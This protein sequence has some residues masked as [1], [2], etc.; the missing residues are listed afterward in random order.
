MSSLLSRSSAQYLRSHPWLMALSVLG[1]A[2]GVAIVVAIDLAN[3]SAS[4]AFR[5]STDTVTGEATHQ[6]VGAG[7]GL[8][9]GIYRTLRTEHRFRSIAPVIE[10]YATL[11]AADEART[12]QLLGVDPFAEGPFRPYAGFGPDSDLEL[13]PLLARSTVLIGAETARELGVEPGQSLTVSVEGVQHTVE[14][15][16]VL[17][18]D[19]ERSRRAVENLIVTDIATAQRLFDARG[20]LSRIDAIIED[21]STEDRLRAALPEGVHLQRSETRTDTVAQMTRAFDLNLTALSLLALVVGAFLIYNTMLFS[22][23]QRRPLIGRLRALGVTRREIFRLVLSEAAVLGLAGTILGVLAGIVLAQGLV[24]IITR[25]ITDLYFVVTVQQLSIAPWTLA[26][27]AALGL[28]LTLVAALFPARE[29]ANAPVSMVLQRST[30]ESDI[31]Q[32]APMLALSGAGLAGVGVAI[33]ALIGGS[34]AWS[35]VGLL[36]LI[37]GITAATPL[38]V[39]GMA[40]A[41]R[42]VMDAVAGVLGRMA[43]RGVVSTLSRTGVA[44]AAL[45][46]AV[47]ATIGVGIMIDSF[48]GTVETWLQQSLQADVYVQ[49]PS[50]SF[51]RATATVAPALVASI[52]DTDGVDGVYTVRNVDVTADVGPTELIAIT[53]GPQTPDTY[54]LKSQE[55]AV[56][57]AFASDDVVL[58]SEPYSNRYGVETGDTLTLQTDRGEQDFAVIAVYFDYAS[59]MGSVLMSRTTYD[60]HYDDDRVSGVAVTAA[61]GIDVDA[62]IADLRAEAS[63]VQ[64][65]LIQSNQALREASMDIF[66]QTFAVTN[67]LRL[68]AILVAF[69]GVLTAL[70]ALQ[71]ERNREFAVMRASGMTP[72]QVGGLVTMQTGLMGLFAGLLSLPL[73]YALA[74]VLIYVINLRSFGWTL[75]MDV[76]AGIL[77]QAVLL[78]IAAALLAGLYPAR[79]MA[80]ANP[81]LALK[82]E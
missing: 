33:L 44:I 73:G 72:S 78:A 74:Y 50:P 45:T 10:G 38:A 59:D 22:V 53:P 18:P 48:R 67:V 71:L 46:V 65:V 32:R 40:K 7:E 51:R 14:L 29:A 79:K 25:T 27:G 41:A 64:D 56:W 11:E 20:Q 80:T 3:T 26:K 6:V 61:S 35:Y 60:R 66:D 82:E 55:G 58:V 36:L 21:E 76:S 34:I 15:M 17:E 31:Q 5:L 42:P 52:R 24:Q 2:L 54:E 57:D 19:D 69:I 63:G 39:I 12:F 8:D 4:D 28:G 77:L 16:G 47:A 81:A 43:A 9:E 68:L 37:L 13:E 23:V 30:S 70:M 49:A 1:I 75:Q 62:L